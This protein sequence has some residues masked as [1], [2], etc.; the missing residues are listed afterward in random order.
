M[1][2][3]LEK[4]RIRLQE[5]DQ[6][7][8][9]LLSERMK[10][11]KEIGE[12]KF[13]NKIEIFQKDFWKYASLKRRKITSKTNLD[14]EFVEKLFSIIHLQSIKTQENILDKCNHEE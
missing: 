8:I 7:I 12:L 14:I 11:S 3:A 4:Y 1:T 2:Q 10:I 13:K 9:L 5:I 6:E